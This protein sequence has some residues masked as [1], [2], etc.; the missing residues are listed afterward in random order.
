MPAISPLSLIQTGALLFT[1]GKRAQI[2]DDPVD[3]PH[4]S[5]PHKTIEVKT[6]WGVRVRKGSSQLSDNF[7]TIVQLHREAPDTCVWPTEGA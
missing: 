7:A 1:P 6:V 5:V 4:G 3:F 2:C